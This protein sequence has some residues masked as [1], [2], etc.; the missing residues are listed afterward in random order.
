MGMAT[1]DLERLL[2]VVEAE[3]QALAAL[4]HRVIAL[5]LVLEAGEYRFVATCVDELLA[6][7]TQL[8]DC[9]SRRAAVTSALAADEARPRGRTTVLAAAPEPLRGMLADHEQGI[10][11]HGAEIRAQVECCRQLAR[12]RLRAAERP[13]AARERMVEARASRMVE[14]RASRMEAE[15][16]RQ[17]CRSVLSALD[18][19]APS[20]MPHIVVVPD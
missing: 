18:D 14:A 7:G 15:L 17:L 12:A 2:V 10:R 9:S 4:L 8:A 6:A 16:R 1:A 20:A 5:R 19:L 3:R 11:G 13:S